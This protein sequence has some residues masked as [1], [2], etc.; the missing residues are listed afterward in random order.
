MSFTNPNIQI[1]GNIL[2]LINLPLAT[3]REIH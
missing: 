3:F 2:L 1:T